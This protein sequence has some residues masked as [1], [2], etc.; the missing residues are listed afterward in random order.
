MRKKLKQRKSKEN[1]NKK[2]EK[3]EEVQKQKENASQIKPAQCSSQ[4][5]FSEAV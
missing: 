4:V 3:K 5:Y 2:I 1:E